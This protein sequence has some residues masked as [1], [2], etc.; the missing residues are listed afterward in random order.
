MRWGLIALLA[1]CHARLADPAGP[2]GHGV[3]PG[4]DAA[5]AHDDAAPAVDA[6]LG[7]WG[8]P[9]KI[10]G[11]HD[12]TNGE[13]DVTMSWSGGELVYAVAVP[14]AKKH[15]YTMTYANGV[16]GTPALL[17]F[18]GIADDSSPRF[19]PDDLTL[20]FASDRG[21]ASLDIYATTRATVGGAWQTPALVAGPNTARVDKW[22][23]PCG[24]NHYMVV[25]ATANG[26]TDLYEGLAGSAP[27][28]VASLNSTAN[29]TS[30]FLT[31]DCLD[32]YF[33]SARGA[34]VD[35]YTSHRATVA[36]PWPAPTLVA[37]FGTADNEEDPWL[38]P[39]GR[40]FLFARATVAA[41]A[42]KDLYFSVR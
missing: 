6:A 37:D 5:S 38:S 31:M 21:G 9:Q 16:F 26:D 19:S 3:D 25:S 28:A 33:A 18:S 32:I 40:L 23:A 10:P 35:L 30:A 29:E 27:T 24:G 13:D 2:D 1:A 12:P 14:G 4:D 7:P 34:T 42:Q 15:L 20:Y 36:S 39:S 17:P 22:Y 41:P 8:T 11:A